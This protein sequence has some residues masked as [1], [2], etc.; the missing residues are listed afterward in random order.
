MWC[1]IRSIKRRCLAR[2][3]LFRVQFDVAGGDLASLL[4][5]DW[6]GKSGGTRVMSP[7]CHCTCDAPNPARKS[8]ISDAQWRQQYCSCGLLRAT[9]RDILQPA[10]DGA[11][12]RLAVVR[13][14]HAT[15]LILISSAAYPLTST[16]SGQRHRGARQ[17]GCT[18]FEINFFK[19]RLGLRN[20]SW[21][22]TTKKVP[23]PGAG[24]NRSGDSE[25]NCRNGENGNFTKCHY[26]NSDIFMLLLANVR[27]Y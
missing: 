20:S 3:K 15:L 8:D 22:D 2:C 27:R 24:T 14:V 10:T 16:A 25:D 1:G 5:E 19:Q 13:S 26:L 21:F 12:S 6:R 17:F 18:E 4:P 11:R 23:T 7:S 9:F